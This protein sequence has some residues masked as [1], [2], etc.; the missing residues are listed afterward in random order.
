MRFLFPLSCIIIALVIF[1]SF[2]DPL[3]GDIKNL[4]KDVATYNLALSNSTELQ[5]VRDSLV[6][7]YKNIKPE[8]KKRLE[9]FLPNTVNNIRFILEIEQIANMHSMPIKNIKFEPAEKQGD[10]KTNT[11]G[12]VIAVNDPLTLK[13]YGTFPIEFTTEGKYEIFTQFI[14]DI[15]RNLRLVDIKSISFNIPA[16]PEKTLPTFDPNLYTY[17]L[18]VETY[19]LK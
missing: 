12:T 6:E 5:K 4:K 15:E 17:T 14:R 1:F 3:Y 11:S 2:V 13:P 10:T 9:N 7:T 8:D 16:I 18:K 19:W